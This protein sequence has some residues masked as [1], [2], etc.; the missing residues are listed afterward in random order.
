V[1]RA[2]VSRIV[3]LVKPQTFKQNARAFLRWRK[4]ARNK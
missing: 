4:T 2:G 3:S 1:L